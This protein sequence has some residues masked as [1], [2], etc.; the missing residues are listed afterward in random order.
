MYNNLAAISVVL[1]IRIVGGIEEI[2][3]KNLLIL[4]KK[5]KE[6]TCCQRWNHFTVRN[7]CDIEWV[8][9]NLQI[10]WMNCN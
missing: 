7:K 8:Q 2:I 3:Y 1:S 5:Q 4:E 6:I 9:T 10:L